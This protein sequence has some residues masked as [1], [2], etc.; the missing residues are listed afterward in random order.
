MSVPSER[1]SEPTSCALMIRSFN[2]DAPSNPPTAPAL[3]FT[4]KQLEEALKAAYKLVTEGKFTEALKVTGSGGEVH[5]GEQG[6]GVSR[7]H[8]AP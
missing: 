8:W 2:A 6:S 7:G 4:L 5:Q 1:A 3:V